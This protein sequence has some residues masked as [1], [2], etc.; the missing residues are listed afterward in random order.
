MKLGNLLDIETQ[1]RSVFCTDG[2]APA[3]LSGM[4]H[5]NTVPYIVEISKKQQIFGQLSKPYKSKE[6]GFTSLHEA[7]IYNIGEK[8]CATITARYWKGIAGNG[9]NMIIEV[10]YDK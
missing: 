7:S 8:C 6:E 4:S 10:E 1:G 2:I 9:D 5:G 3:L